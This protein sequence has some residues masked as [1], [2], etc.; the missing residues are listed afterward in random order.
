MPI[1]SLY[2]VT[3]IHWEFHCVILNESQLRLPLKLNYHYKSKVSYKSLNVYSI[4]T[5]VIVNDGAGSIQ[6]SAAGGRLLYIIKLS[7][8]L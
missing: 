7:L 8:T 4:L 6:L 2:H 1:Q 5:G 3:Q